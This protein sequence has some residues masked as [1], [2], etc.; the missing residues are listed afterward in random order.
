M[1]KSN[2]RRARGNCFILQVHGRSPLKIALN[3]MNTGFPLPCSLELN[4]STALIFFLIQLFGM[5]KRRLEI[6]LTM[7]SKFSLKNKIINTPK[8]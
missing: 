8:Q 7:V 2:Y 4:K 1:L 6:H 5:I 3:G